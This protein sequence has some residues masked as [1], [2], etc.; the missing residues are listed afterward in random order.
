MEQSLQIIEKME[1]HIK[2]QLSM[3][4]WVIEGGEGNEEEEEE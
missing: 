3:I 4:G 2:E 1:E